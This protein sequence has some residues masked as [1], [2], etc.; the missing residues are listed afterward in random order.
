MALLPVFSS[1]ATF[2]RINV[3]PHRKPR[4]A[5]AARVVP[6]RVGTITLVNEAEHFVLIDTGVAA[7][8]PIGTA[9]KCFTGEASSGVVAVGN[10]YRRP[11]VVADIVQGSPKKGDGAFQ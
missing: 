4:P 7:V 2:E 8:P 1:C 9:L 11:F 10:V 5:L 6:Q 3:L